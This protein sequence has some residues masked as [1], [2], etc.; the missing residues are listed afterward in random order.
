MKNSSRFLDQV[1]R[2][3]IIASVTTLVT[4][5]ALLGYMKHEERVS[6]LR[7]DLAV[8][9]GVVNEAVK[10]IAEDQVQLALDKGTGDVY[11][12][13]LGRIIQFHGVCP[14]QRNL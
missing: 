10:M 14:A 11:V 7:T 4:L 3:T 5:L 13:S 9:E 8:A 2:G 1:L 12:K 6:G